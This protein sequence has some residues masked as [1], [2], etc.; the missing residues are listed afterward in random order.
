[1]LLLATAALRHHSCIHYFLHS[2]NEYESCLQNH[3]YIVYNIPP[4]FHVQKGSTPLLR[5]AKKGHANIVNFLLKN[6]SD[7]FEQNDVSGTYKLWSMFLR[8]FYLSRAGACLITVC[9][10]IALMLYHLC[11]L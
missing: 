6:G 9:V 4:S 1:M 11:M 5:A 8:M 10:I 3:V 2:A 7:V